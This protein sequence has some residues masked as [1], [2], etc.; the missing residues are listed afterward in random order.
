M[1]K[2]WIAVFALAY[3]GAHAYVIVDQGCLECCALGGSCERAFNGK[4]GICCSDAYPMVCCPADGLAAGLESSLSATKNY[5][6]KYTPSFTRKI[7]RIDTSDWSQYCSDKPTTT[8]PAPAPAPTPAPTPAPLSAPTAAPTSA[9]GGS[10]ASVTTQS[11]SKMADY[12]GFFLLIMVLICAYI[13]CFNHVFAR[14]A[15]S[16]Q[17]APLLGGGIIRVES[18]A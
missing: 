17:Q 10:P 4:P 16:V 13:Y 14:E 5:H 9:S 1:D 11:T 2:S 18:R 15:V 6:C 12:S 7:A 8:T 3:G